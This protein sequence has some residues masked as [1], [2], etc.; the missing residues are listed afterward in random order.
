MILYEYMKS[1]KGTRWLRIYP[2]PR[3]VWLRQSVF[4]RSVKDRPRNV[5]VLAVEC[6][7]LLLRSL[8]VS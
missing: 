3:K 1:A 5:A 6:W 7:W 8:R 4:A 2:H